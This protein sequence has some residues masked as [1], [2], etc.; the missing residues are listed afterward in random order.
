ML[1]IVAVTFVAV[2]IVA[3]TT[4]AVTIVALTIVALTIVSV[5]RFSLLQRTLTV[6]NYYTFNRLMLFYLVLHI[7]RENHFLLG[8]LLIQ[9]LEHVWIPNESDGC[10][11]DDGRD[12]GSMCCS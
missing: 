11:V 8:H 1:I 12:Y 9:H 10:L 4:V 5:L 2:I 6:P 7:L 3:V